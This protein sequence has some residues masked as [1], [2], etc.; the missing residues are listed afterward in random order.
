MSQTDFRQGFTRDGTTGDLLVKMVSGLVTL[1]ASDVRLGAMEICDA[2]TDARAPVSATLGLSVNPTSLPGTAANGGV[3]PA[4]LHVL[5]G[6]TGAA[7]A[8]LKTDATGILKVDIAGA[9]VPVAVTGPATDAQLRATP[10]PVSGTVTITPP[11]LTKGTQGAT[12]LSTQDLKDAGRNQIN[13]HMTIP[14]LTTNTDALQSLTGYKSGAAVGATAT[15]AVVSAGKTLRVTAITLTYVA[16]ATAGS[17]KFTLRANTGGVV[18]IT[19]PAVCAWVV[20]GPAA[21]AGVA[22]TVDVAIPDGLEFAAGTGIGISM[23]GLSATQVATAVGYGQIAINGF[24][25]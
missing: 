23:I 19:S 16:I 1:D 22:Q 4:V 17:A 18:Q 12:G 11:A 3:L 10:L 14:V 8:A 5:A 25:Y 15:P 20:G 7:V 6:Y 13:F 21:V 24:E 9:D 2:T